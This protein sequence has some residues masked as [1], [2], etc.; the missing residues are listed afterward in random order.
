FQ[1]RLTQAPQ[2][3]QFALDYC[4]EHARTRAEQEGVLAALRFKCDVLWVQMDAL[5]H[6]YVAPKHV[7]PGA[8]VPAD[9]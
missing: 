9:H 8:F 4:K 1:P 2:D 7:P 6:A 3:V 5:H